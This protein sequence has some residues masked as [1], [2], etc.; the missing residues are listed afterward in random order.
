MGGFPPTAVGQ[1]VQIE[2][3][4]E[5]H[6]MDKEFIREITGRRI[7]SLAKE[8]GGGGVENVSDALGTVS[9][10]AKMVVVQTNTL[11]GP[12]DV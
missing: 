10:R 3:A 6:A 8:N 1:E 12:E 9:E 4:G 2:Y 5:T 11:D 7:H